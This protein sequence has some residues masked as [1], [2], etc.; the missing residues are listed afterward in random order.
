MVLANAKRRFLTKGVEE[1]VNASSCTMPLSDGRQITYHKRLE[2]VTQ[3]SL[4]LGF[5]WLHGNVVCL[6]VQA[7]FG[8]DDGDD[9][10]N[11]Q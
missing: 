7:I 1:R 6:P 11:G 3:S 10:V 4:K 2:P 5:A 8:V 9:V